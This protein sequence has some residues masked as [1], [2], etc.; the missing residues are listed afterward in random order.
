MAAK[1]GVSRNAFYSY[2]KDHPDSEFSKWLEDFSDLCGELTMAAALDGS[3]NVVGAIFVAK[4][5]YQW[6]DVISVQ[7]TV[8]TPITQP[9]SPEEIMEKYK[10]FMMD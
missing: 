3:V 4:A 8:S 5:R 2:S 6:K 10:D 1:V 7:N 9:L